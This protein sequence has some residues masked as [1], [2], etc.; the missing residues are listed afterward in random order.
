MYKDCTVRFEGNSYVVPHHLV[1]KQI[2]LRVRG[3]QSVLP[4][5]SQPV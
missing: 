3:M 2:I 4:V 1:G 5:Y